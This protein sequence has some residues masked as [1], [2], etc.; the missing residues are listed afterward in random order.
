MITELSNP[1][2]YVEYVLA[3]LMFTEVIKKAVQEA[4]LHPKWV[5]FGV[6]VVMALVGVV[7]E[8]GLM[9]N[10]V[11]FWKLITSFGVSI[12][13]YDYFMKPIKDKFFPKK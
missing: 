3:V 11:N 2:V 12:I 9:H 7:L 1:Y 13:G 5:T 10:A 4:D 6:A 8:T